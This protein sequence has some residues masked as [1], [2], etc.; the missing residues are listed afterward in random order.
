MSGGRDLKIQAVAELV[1]AGAIWG[2]GFVAT[3]WALRSMGPMAMTGWRFILAAVLGISLAL[4]IPSLRQHVTLVQLKLS[5][6]PG[7]LVCLMLG[8]QTWGLKY[9]TATKGGFI[10]T[11]YVLVVPLLEMWWRKRPL[12]RFHFFY[13]ALGLLGVA[14]I[15]DLPSDILEQMRTM[16]PTLP[17]AVITSRERWNIGDFLTLLCAI[18][19]SAHIIYLGFI[20]KKIGSAFVFNCLQSFWAALIPLSLAFAIEES[21]HLNWQD[22]SLPGFLS[23]LFASTMIAFALQVRAQKVLSPSLS[24]LLFLLESPFAAFFAVLLL[25]EHVSGAQWIGAALILLATAGSVWSST[26]PRALS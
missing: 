24:S 8:L 11:L 26:A 12:P 17:K 18:A 1:F 3:I 21:P 16:G 14:L 22:L 23:L 5:F 20:Q 10:T 2:F 4:V 13:V 19:A 25:H 6:I 9:T 7:I 15:C